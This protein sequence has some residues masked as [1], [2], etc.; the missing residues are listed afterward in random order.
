MDRGA[1]FRKEVADVPS[2]YENLN[3]RPEMKGPQ[4]TN[5]DNI[6]ARI[7]AFGCGGLLHDVGHRQV[8]F[9]WCVE[10]AYHTSVFIDDTSMLS[11]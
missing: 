1:I 3:K 7:V 8:K 4:N 5:I 9:L 6:L 10:D 11:T 2:Q